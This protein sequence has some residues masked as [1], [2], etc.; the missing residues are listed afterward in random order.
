ME[1]AGGDN[2]L[3]R[4]ACP[5]DATAVAAFYNEALTAQGWKPLNPRDAGADPG[6]LAFARGA[7]LG[8]IS[9]S[10]GS[11]AGQTIVTVAVRDMRGL[12]TAGPPYHVEETQP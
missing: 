6:I 4:F 11:E 1:Q 7:Q 10:P 12:R 2:R 5:L 3:R 8:I 9:L